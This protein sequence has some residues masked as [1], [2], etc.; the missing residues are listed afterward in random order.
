MSDAPM[1]WLPTTGLT[2]TGLAT[3]RLPM[4]DGPLSRPR[5]PRAATER[6]TTS[7]VRRRPGAGFTLIELMITTAI[8]AVVVAGIFVAVQS[9]Q[10]AYADGQRLRAAQASARNALLYL[11]QR[12]PL[13]GLGISPSLAFDLGRYTTGPCPTADM[14]TCPRDAIDNADELV[15]MARNPRYW[16]SNNPTVEPRGNAWNVVRVTNSTL[17]LRARTGDSFRRGQVLAAVCAGGAEYAYFT[18]GATVPTLTADNATQDVTLVAPSAS[19]PFLRQDLAQTDCFDDGT[20][21]LFLVDRYRF[22]VRPETGTTGARE[23]YLMLDTGTD[24]DGD[25]VVNADDELV[26]A[27]GIESFQVAYD[28]ANGSTVGATPGTI[29]TFADGYPGGATAG[30]L[31][32]LVFPGPAPEPGQSAYVPTSWFAF[33]MGPPPAPERDTNHQA[34]IRFVRLALVARSP[35]PE[36]RVAGTGTLLGLN[37]SSRPAWAGTVANDGFQRVRFES[38]IALPNMTVRGMTFF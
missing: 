34:N 2:V 9:Q 19:D 32:R 23:P 7:A 13:A 30:Q 5:S 12:I 1:T 14:G 26:I 20:T 27:A 36:T 35:D 6:D 15:F 8:V 37:Q 29:I 11:E 33:R 18:V 38:R 28:L 25:D 21:R 3:S 31:T 10:Q 17:T 16:V 24:T 4:T 22:H